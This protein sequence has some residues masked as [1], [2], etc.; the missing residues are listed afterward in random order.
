[1]DNYKTSKKIGIKILDKTQ[2]ENSLPQ[3][4]H[5][6]R[7]IN[8]QRSRKINETQEILNT[9]LMED[10][11]YAILGGRGTGKTSVLYTLVTDLIENKNING[12]IIL[13]PIMPEIIGDQEYSILG[14]IISM[15]GDVVDRLERKIK[16]ISPANNSKYSYWERNKFFQNCR[17]NENNILR[18]QYNEILKDCFT[19][20]KY[21]SNNYS[22]SDMANF[23]LDE[24]KTRYGLMKKLSDFWNILLDTSAQVAAENNKEDLKNCKP[25]IFIM[26]DDLDLSPERSMEVLSSISK[27]FSNAR[28]VLILTASKHELIEVLKCKMYEK[29]VGS[30]FTSL[31]QGNMYE[32]GNNPNDWKGIY[33]IDDANKAA[34]EYFNKIIPPSSRYTLNTYSTIDEKNYYKYSLETSDDFGLRSVN[35]QKLMTDSVNRLLDH[36]HIEEKSNFLTYDESNILS[37]LM[38]FGNKNRNIANSC[39]AIVNAFDELSLYKGEDENNFLYPILDQLFLVFISSNNDTA[40]YSSKRSILFKRQHRKGSLYIDYKELINI[41]NTEKQR[42]ENENLERVEDLIDINVGL[43]SENYKELG[44]IK[45]NLLCL[46]MMMN[47]IENII[48][49]FRNQNGTRKR[50]INGKKELINLLNVDVLLKKEF[51]DVLL[52]PKLFGNLENIESCLYYY[53]YMISDIQRYINLSIYNEELMFN[54][55]ASLFKVY[56]Q[57]NKVL[58]NKDQDWENTLIFLYE[59]YRSDISNI[60]NMEV[61]SLTKLINEI[62]YIGLIDFKQVSLID[63][64]KTF[65]NIKSK[66]SITA[67]CNE[68]LNSFNDDILEK[69]NYD[70]L[71][72]M[73]YD[74]IGTELDLTGNMEKDIKLII[75]KYKDK[76]LIQTAWIQF[77]FPLLDIE[78]KNSEKIESVAL[79]QA[80]TKR[81]K[82]YQSINDLIILMYD[83]IINQ[84]LFK[85]K[86]INLQLTK[87]NNFFIRDTLTAISNINIEF[88]VFAPDNKE[89]NNYCKDYFLAVLQF[90]KYIKSDIKK[91]PYYSQEYVKPLTQDITD[92]IIHAKNFSCNVRK[93]AESKDEYLKLIN[94]L[95]MLQLLSKYY[96]AAIFLRNYNEIYLKNSYEELF[97]KDT[98]YISLNQI[99]N[100]IENYYIKFLIQEG[101]EDEV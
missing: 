10:N 76:N 60:K 92:R 44:I 18:D 4:D 77:A 3:Y 78:L 68:I 91:I 85:I 17:F 33:K 64:I 70:D 83:N 48:V 16:R 53:S 100:S 7:R 96:L 1:M 6:M 22:Y 9:N 11:L 39:L 41:Y 63:E 24:S 61:K 12:D 58:T 79:L 65:I 19:D 30:N 42:M 62:N 57:N 2:L 38:I 5:L 28:I 54:F 67:Q 59:I 21:M 50:I 35:I 86:D 52:I 90:R 15:F 84:V 72:N 71:Y 95:I 97:L 20:S 8:D 75:K 81:L 80:Y 98:Q 27:Y 82:N 99:R 43:R 73:N 34:M 94:N 25:L 56:K 32:F 13:P 23:R 69:I 51:S 47:F 45:K 93:G 74:I 101:F 36:L 46:F 29:I 14:W 55:L 40:K 49:I 87:E 31:L 88:E 89:S 66:S 26:F 37:Y